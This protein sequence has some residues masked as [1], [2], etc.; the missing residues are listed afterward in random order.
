MS[1]NSLNSTVNYSFLFWWVVANLVALPSLLLPYAIGFFLLGSLV[2]MGDGMPIGPF[3]YTVIFI[4]LVLSGALIGAWLGFMQWLPMKA[5][6]ERGA[7][8]IRASALGVAIGAPLSWL[9]YLWI[10]Q[11]G[12]YFSSGDA[13]FPFGV[14]LGLSVG[15]SQWS[16]LRQ[17]GD[18]AGWWILV[19]PVAFTLGIIYS[20]LADTHPLFTAFTALVGVGC[21]TGILLSL[22]LQF[23]KL[24]GAK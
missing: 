2:F 3:G 10:L 20:L 5:R 1:T 24:Q 16:V 13:Y 12:I 21:F 11:S 4:V 22:I 18:G 7:K 8:W 17:E 19:L 9:A 14:L 6:I 23:P 15:V